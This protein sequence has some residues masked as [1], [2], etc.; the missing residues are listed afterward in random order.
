[1]RKI[2]IA[3]TNKDKFK[4]VSEILKSLG[5]KDFSFYNLAEIGQVSKCIEKGPIQERAKQ[6]AEEF[7][8]LMKDFDIVLGVDDGILLPNALEIN[9]ELKKIM[10][11]IFNDNLLKENDKVSICRAFYFITRQKEYSILTKVPFVYHKKKEVLISPNSYPLSQV[12]CPL[13]SKKA[14]ADMNELEEIEYHLKNFGNEFN[15]F[16]SDIE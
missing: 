8:A 3:T 7:K 1:M 4:V 14:V 2:L 12:L 13:G 10:K 15:D 9:P 16:L 5:L 6:K 11:Q